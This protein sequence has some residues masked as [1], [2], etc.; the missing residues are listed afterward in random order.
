MDFL[1]SLH[2]A[3]RSAFESQGAPSDWSKKKTENLYKALDPEQQKLVRD[4]ARAAAENSQRAEQLEA[5]VSQLSSSLAR[6]STNDSAH[7]AEKDAEIQE[8]RNELAR[9][10]SLAQASGVTEEHKTKPSTLPKTAIVA[11]T[12]RDLVKTPQGK[13]VE[14]LTRQIVMIR[15][16]VQSVRADATLLD[17]LRR[18]L[19][20]GNAT[21]DEAEKSMVRKT[22]VANI[23][24]W[25]IENKRPSTVPVDTWRKLVRDSIADP[26]NK[27]LYQFNL[28]N[29]N[30]FIEVQVMKVRDL[31]FPKIK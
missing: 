30:T 23:E 19:K 11:A 18:Q 1:N 4:L 3:L 13:M 17:T 25:L 7:L 22:V 20:T 26:Q 14:E 28:P 31:L 21:L 16:F 24:N 27:S 5:V 8:L 2:N 29:L 6:V 10:T 12:R 9:I 15:E